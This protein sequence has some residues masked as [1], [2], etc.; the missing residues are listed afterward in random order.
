[1]SSGGAVLAEVLVCLTVIALAARS[2]SRELEPA[3]TSFELLR[4]DLAEAVHL[5]RRDAGRAEASQRV[6]RR[7]GNARPSR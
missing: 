3:R 6:L 2:L 4:R 5:V 1:M 7:P